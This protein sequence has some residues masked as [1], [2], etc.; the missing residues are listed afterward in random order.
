MNELYQEFENELNSFIGKQINEST[1]VQIENAVRHFANKL[2]STGQIP[3]VE[4]S[5]LG[6]CDITSCAKSGTIE[7]NQYT[8][9]VLDNAHQIY[10]QTLDE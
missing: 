7:F 6:V 5:K 4:I 1:I 8:K 3:T 9:R 2:I 10:L